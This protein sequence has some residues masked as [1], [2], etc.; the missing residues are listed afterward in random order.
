M[1]QSYKYIFTS[2]SSVER[3]AK[4][5][6][7]GNARIHGMT[8][9]TPASIAYVATQVNMLYGEPLYYLISLQARFALSSSPVFTRSDTVT[10]SERFYTSILGLLEDQDE[11]K[12]VDD[13]LAWWNR[14]VL[15]VHLFLFI[16]H[17]FRQIFPN[18]SQPSRPLSKHSALA[19]IKA[20]RAAIKERAVLMSADTNQL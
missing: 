13:L 20:K 15:H 5:T 1:F 2:P 12:E 18:Y 9:V 14:L 10:D 19:K 7:S 6:R 11:V 3:E 16:S 8:R 17:Y 4:A